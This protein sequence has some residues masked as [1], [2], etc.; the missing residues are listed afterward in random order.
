MRARA[1]R[2]QGSMDRVLRRRSSSCWYRANAEAV[3][4]ASPT[5]WPKIRATSRTPTKRRGRPRE[6]PSSNGANPCGHALPCGEGEGRRQRGRDTCSGVN[7]VLRT[8]S[9]DAS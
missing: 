2:D 8:D 6:V 7:A 9:A 3:R 5:S 1:L 4:L